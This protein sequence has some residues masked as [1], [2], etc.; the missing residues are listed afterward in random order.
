MLNRRHV[1]SALTLSGVF[2]FGS[3]ASAMDKKPF[4]QKAV[5][6]A[7]RDRRDAGQSGQNSAGTYKGYPLSEWYRTDGW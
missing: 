6:A 1:L 4:H 7:P 3:V 2:S 5:A